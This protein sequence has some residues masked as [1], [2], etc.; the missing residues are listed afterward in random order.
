MAGAKQSFRLMRAYLRISADGIT[1]PSVEP[2]SPDG[3]AVFF[4]NGEHAP[5]PLNSSTLHK[6]VI[7]LETCASLCEAHID[8]HFGGQKSFALLGANHRFTRQSN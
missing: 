3:G 1:Q 6:Y 7:S 8:Q 5:Q 2:I 4:G